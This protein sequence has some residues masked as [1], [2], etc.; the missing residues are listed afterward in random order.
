MEP[1]RI[2]LDDGAPVLL[3]QLEPGDGELVRA[4]FARLSPESRWRR[5]MSPVDELTDEDLAYL[6]GVDHHRHEA[7]VALHAETGEVL[8]IGRWVRQPGRREVAELAVAVVDDWQGRGIGTELVGELNALARAEGINRY[9]A[10]VS[11]DNVQVIEALE[12]HGAIRR[13]SSG[14]PEAVE[15]EAPVPREWSR[16]GLA[17][18]LRAAAAGHLRLAGAAA[19]WLRERMPWPRA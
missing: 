2:E 6:T 7:V 1:R 5:F 11:I 10:A 4:A 15:F 13:G 17:A 9:E 3:R 16:S 12:R 18:G 19:G 14:E 8:G